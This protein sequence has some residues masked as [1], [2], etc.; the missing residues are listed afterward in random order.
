M[1]DGVDWMESDGTLV[2][3]G[4]SLAWTPESATFGGKAVKVVLKDVASVDGAG[5]RL[6]VVMKSGARYRFRVPSGSGW[7]RDVRAALK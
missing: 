4:G 1:S 2:F 3:D 5:D 7:A 6:T